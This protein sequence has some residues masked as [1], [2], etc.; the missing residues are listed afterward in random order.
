MQVLPLYQLSFSQAFLLFMI[1]SVV[2]WCSEV[3]YVGV[4]YEHK[5]VNRGFL[6]G[7][8]C[9]IYG[10][11][12]VVILLLPPQLYKTWI[13]LFLASMILCT[14]VEYFISWL[15]EK[16]FHTL[17]WD[18]SHYKV[19]LNGRICLLNSVLFGLMGMSVIHFV[20]PYIMKFLNMFSE[21][22]LTV[23][24]QVIAV[25]LAADIIITVRR[26][27]DFNATMEKLK[28]FGETLKDHYGK[29]EWFHDGTLSEM[30]ASVKEHAAL[31]K[32]KFSE[33]FLARLESIQSRHRNVE[34]FVKRFPT[35]KSNKYTD[36][37]A[38]IK[39]QIKDRIKK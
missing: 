6:H 20:M 24:S 18:Y 37:L 11:G 39:Q 13:P 7:P 35:L 15:L 2:G 31:D 36:G 34:S 1:F 5:F 14:C 33:S 17:W 19:N 8:L 4:F 30:I 3:F 32:S 16:M 26:L 12:G 21:I 23:T 29:E 9:P 10:F 38:H 22:A 25:I 28:N 27:V